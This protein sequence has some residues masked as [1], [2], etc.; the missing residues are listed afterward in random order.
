MIYHR[1]SQ[2]QG[3]SAAVNQGV[4]LAKGTWI[5]P[6]RCTSSRRRTSR[7]P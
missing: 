6:R 2:N 1:Q 4:A 3:H 7:T 5:K